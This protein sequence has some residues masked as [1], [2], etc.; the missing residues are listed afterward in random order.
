MS[1]FLSGCPTEHLWQSN[2]RL[3]WP[4]KL[5]GSFH[6]M[7]FKTFKILIRYT[8]IVITDFYRDGALCS[9][10][11]ASKQGQEQRKKTIP[12]SFLCLAKAS[13]ILG[14]G[15]QPADRAKGLAGWHCCQSW[16]WRP[17]LGDWGSRNPETG[18]RLRRWTGTDVIHHPPSIHFS[19]HEYTEY[20]PAQGHKWW[21]CCCSSPSLQE[22]TAWWWTPSSIL[23]LLFLYILCWARNR[24]ILHGNC[25]F[26]QATWRETLLILHYTLATRNYSRQRI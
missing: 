6:F 4:C 2:Q 1:V 7:S 11:S 26:Q 23:S 13:Y 15:K 3:S 9:F 14:K 17:S 25:Y 16:T 22:N 8:T 12:A 21:Q 24:D 20:Q 10:R 5:W 18:K 19:P